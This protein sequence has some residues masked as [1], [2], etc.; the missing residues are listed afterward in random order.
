MTE[1]ERLEAGC[2]CHTTPIDDPGEMCAECWIAWLLREKR[3]KGE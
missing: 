2:R 1:P 3:G